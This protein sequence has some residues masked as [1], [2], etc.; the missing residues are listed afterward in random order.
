M[1]TLG[2]ILQTSTCILSNDGS[3]LLVACGSTV[4]LHSV[5]TGD[6]LLVLS[7]HAGDV[8]AICRHTKN[9]ALVRLQPSYQL[10][11][12]LVEFANV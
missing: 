3:R 12:M 7:G 9:E 4:R 6:C 8:T 5:L 1:I 11:S 10:Q 2:G